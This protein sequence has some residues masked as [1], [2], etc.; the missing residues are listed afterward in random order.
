MKNT[1]EGEKGRLDDTKEYISNLE[2]R[3]VKITESKTFFF[4]RRKKKLKI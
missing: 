3:V 2:D 4:A 1:L